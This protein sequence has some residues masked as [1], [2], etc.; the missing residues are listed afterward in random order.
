[1]SFQ[2]RSI[3][4]CAFQEV[5][6][7]NDT[8]FGYNTAVVGSGNIIAPLQFKEIG[9]DDD[10]K[11]I[12]WSSDVTLLFNQTR[13]SHSL[14]SEQIRQWLQQLDLN[15]K[16]ANNVSYDNV[17]DDLILATIK[18]RHIQSLSELKAYASSL[19]S[20]MDNVKGNLTDLEKQ[21]VQAKAAASAS[22]STS[23]VQTSD[24]NLN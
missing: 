22:P 24:P 13:I 4:S 21:I 16:S 20:D 12:Q 14:S 9:K 7:P 3:H 1:M 10:D 15:S 23:G 8:D 19:M 17:S 18:S 2:D 5:Q 11:S 6:K